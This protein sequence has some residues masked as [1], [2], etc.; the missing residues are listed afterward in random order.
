MNANRLLIVYSAVLTLGCAIGLAS[1]AMANQAPGT[2]KAQFGEID[3]QRINIREP[4]GTIRMVLSNTAKAPGIYWRNVERPHPSGRRTAG[5]LFFNEEGTE[6]GGLTFRGQRMPDGNVSS[7]LHLSF[8]QYEQ[9]QVITFSQDENGG[10]RFAGMMV[11]DVPDE[12]VDFDLFQRLN[13]MPEAE[14][15]AEIR[16]LRAAGVGGRDRVLIGKTPDRQSAILLSDA[17]G[18]PRIRMRVAA[19]GASAIE[20]LDEN[21]AVVRNLTPQD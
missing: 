9:D 4:D 1:G 6:N 3:V 10:R 18:R 2:E 8:D 13:Q 14:R 7:N 15:A 17:L 21:G 11:R 5:M 16:R 12:P 19:D 20:F